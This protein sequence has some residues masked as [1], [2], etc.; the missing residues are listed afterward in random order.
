MI[1]LRLDRLDPVV[2]RVLNLVAVAGPSATLPVLGAASGLEG[3]ELLDATDVAVAAGLLVEDGAGRLAMPHAL[4][5]Q[6]IRARIGRTRRLDLHR[7]IAAA[8]ELA[9]EPGSSPSMLAHHLLEAGSLVERDVRI[10]AGLAAGWSS[11]DVGAYEDAA[12]W[13]ERVDALVTDQVDDRDRA[14]LALLRCD[15]ARAQGDRAVGRGGSA[16]GRASGAGRR[17]SRC[18]WPEPP[19]AG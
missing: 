9:S 17:A 3:D 6:A 19:R 8:I 16:G 18:S 1:G 11:L 15:T 14:E 4:I 10:R 5:G 2:G 7:R 12:A 13:V